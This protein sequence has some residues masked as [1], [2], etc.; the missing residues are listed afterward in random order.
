MITKFLQKGD[1]F[2]LLINFKHP[3]AKYRY[4]HGIPPIDK[5]PLF[6]S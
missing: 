3:F 4:G 1:Q 5:K 6:K 2:I